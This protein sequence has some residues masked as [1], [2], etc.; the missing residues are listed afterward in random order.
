MRGPRES[1]EQVLLLAVPHHAMPTCPSPVPTRVLSLRPS[2]RG[3]ERSKAKTDTKKPKT[4][5]TR[6]KGCPRGP[7]GG[8]Q[9]TWPLW[10]RRGGMRLKV[11]RSTLRPLQRVGVPCGCFGDQQ[12]MTTHGAS[13]A[14]N[15]SR[16]LYLGAGNLGEPQPWGNTPTGS[17]APAAR[18][19][20]GSFKAGPDCDPPGGPACPPD[21]KQSHSEG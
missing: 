21:L 20:C 10:G 8:G 4:P 7:T 12:A 11:R 6:P 2:L 17:E 18:V 16:E 15:P 9:G 14:A 13:R 19:R 1:A 5:R 3:K